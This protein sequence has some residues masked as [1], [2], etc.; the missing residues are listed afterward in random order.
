MRIFQYC[1]IP[2]SI[3][4]LVLAGCSRGT[5][6][7]YPIKA[8]PA[9]NIKLTDNM[10]APA[11]E[12]NLEVTLPYVVDKLTSGGSTGGSGTSKVLE[13]IA[14]YLRQGDYP[15]LEELAD[16]QIARI[17]ATQLPDG[18]FGR[19]G[20]GQ[21]RA[22]LSDSARWLGTDDFGETGG[23]SRL[24][25]SGH[26]Y[27]AAVEYYF[28]TGKKTLL[29]VAEK[30]ANLLLSVFGPGKLEAYPFHPEIELA[31]V[32]LYRATGK[33]DYL[34]L[35]RFFLDARGPNGTEYSQSNMKI[36]D[37]TEATGHA[38]RALYLYS[39]VTDIVALQDDNS[40]HEAIDA[41]WNSVA[42]S[43]I[44]ITG[45]MGGYADHEAFG[46]PYSLPNVTAYNETCASIAG[47]LWNHRMFMLEGD[48]KYYDMLEMTLYNSLLSG[49]SLTGDRFFYPNPLDSHS[50]YQRAS[51][52][53]V[54]CCPTNM[55]RFM[56]QV[57][58]LV[59]ATRGE[60]L[61]IN[62]FISNK[63]AIDLPSGR[64][65]VT[66]E[67][68]YP[69]EGKVDIL[70]EPDEATPFSLRLRIPSWAMDRPFQSGL[71]NYMA[72]DAGEINVLLNG[73]PYS[74]KIDHGYAVIDRT[75]EKGDMVTLEIPIK[76]RKVVA[77]QQVVDDRG[78]FALQRGPVVYCL[79]GP[80]NKDAKVH[81]ILVDGDAV[82]K[83][84]KECRMDP[85]VYTLETEGY[86]YAEK[87]GAGVFREE[88]Q[89]KAI[90]YY[91]WANRGPSG[92]I[93]WIPYLEEEVQPIPYYPVTIASE[94]SVSSSYDTTTLAFV[95]DQEIIPYNQNIPM[96]RYYRWPV[97]DQELWLQYDFA[98]RE[99]ISSTSV[100]WYDN[101]PSRM[102]TW[103]D[104]IPYTCCRVPGSWQ[105]LYLDD[106]GKWKPVD[107]VDEYSTERDRYNRVGFSPV[108][109]TSVRLTVKRQPGSCAAGVQEWIVE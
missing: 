109:T 103:Y 85:E 32:K 91:L 83:E 7:D 102:T 57:P 62:L 23:S 82:F 27:E 30:N 75:W 94:S 40:Y 33:R 18:D 80:D 16:T 41:I 25:S 97:S 96:T 53:G 81:N 6:N 3:A 84:G 74:W 68:G 17:A 59:Y 71:Y 79:E 46:P 64:T 8:V 12:R 50:E 100:Y 108:S 95:N 31:L 45:G 89:V 65:A 1:I 93:V 70:L 14:Y 54:S 77:D 4:L 63:A 48:A 28:S 76:A 90:P 104:G 87:D 15:A 98:E 52:Y 105:L 10:W 38:V 49:I 26:L 86:S 67:T 21:Q 101:E 43:K 37:Q 69:W 61:Y 47:I 19:P 106:T 72:N 5:G 107:P 92:M 56:P 11:I 73:E 22:A 55:V 39:G 66:M 9:E 99:I 2:V 88:Q 60:E 42:G 35:A 36:T 34:D 78:R 20:S 51:W 13:G 44:Y 58:G 24:Y 29:D